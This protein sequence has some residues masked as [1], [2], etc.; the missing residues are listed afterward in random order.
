MSMMKTIYYEKLSY[1]GFNSVA[2]SP[3]KCCHACG[4]V[5]YLV[6]TLDTNL[7]WSWQRVPV[8]ILY[9]FHVCSVHICVVHI[10]HLLDVTH[11]YSMQSDKIVQSMSLVCML[12]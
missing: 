5:L 6:P 10:N 11:V 2:C 12:T 4:V 7:V 1:I 3:L 8:Q 9:V